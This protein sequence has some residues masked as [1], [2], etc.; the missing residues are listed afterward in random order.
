MSKEK[1]SFL[2]IK[3]GDCDFFFGKHKNSKFS[4]TRCGKVQTKIQIFD[5]TNDSEELH[6]LVSLN[7]IP[8]GLRVDFN[9][10]NNKKSLKNYSE[11][12]INLIPLILRDSSN[13]EGEIILSELK[14]F[15]IKNKYALSFEKVIEVAEL[16]G[17]I[18]R[19]SNEKWLLLG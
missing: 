13:I 2:V 18:L 9:K 12:D 6:R 14:N 4:C 3:C 11:D 8:E 7:N 17:L 19:I 1:P 16:E 10:L 5:R 15:M